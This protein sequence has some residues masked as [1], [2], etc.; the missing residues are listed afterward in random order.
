MNLPSE[1][2]HW[3]DGTATTF[4]PTV[5]IPDFPDDTV[6]EVEPDAETAEL[7]NESLDDADIDVGEEV[8][9]DVGSEPGELGESEP[10]ED[11]ASDDEVDED[12]DEVEGDA[13]TPSESC[14]LYTSPSPRDLS[15]SRMPSSA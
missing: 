4:D 5:P 11:G 12:G 9:V 1:P 7:L 10:G 3:S 14:L 8:A 6:P 13:A 15:T 2:W